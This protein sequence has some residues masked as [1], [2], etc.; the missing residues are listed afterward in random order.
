MRVFQPTWVLAAGGAAAGLLA[1]TQP[2]ALLLSIIAAAILAAAALFTPLA[3]AGIMLVLAPLRTLVITEAVYNL[4]LDP[5]QLLFIVTLALWAFYRIRHR[6]PLFAA[7]PSP[8]Y[9]PVLGFATLT[10]LTLFNTVSPAAWLTEW[11]KWLV[12]LLLIVFVLDQGRH[13]RWQWLLL[14]LVAAAAANAVVGLYIFFGGSGADHL[15]INNRFFRAFGTFGQ[16]NPFGGFMGLTLPLALMAAYGYSLRLFRNW[17]NRPLKPQA[18]IPPVF[19]LM[20]ALLLASGVLISWSRGA[21]LA[22]AVAVAVM[23]FALPYRLRYSLL[24]LA[25]AG[26]LAAAAW[27]GGLLPASIIERVTG[28]AEELLAFEDVRGVEITPANYAVIERL[29]HWQAALNMAR[30]HPWLGVGLGAYGAA[31]DQYRL[32]NWHEPL[33]HAHNYY[34]NI[35]AEAGIIGLIGYSLLWAMVFLFTWR[36]R[37]HPDPLARALG[38]GLLGAWVYLAVHSLLDNLYVNNLFLHLGVMFGILAVL[39][40][41][42]S[43]KVQLRWQ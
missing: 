43:R 17:R 27:F 26:S 36:L 3:A 15:L 8:V 25:L 12:I 34:L 38:I 11:L 40:N 13:E 1:A 7:L 31:Y 23:A 18:F 2:V 21:W 37:R 19:Y 41:Q 28:S 30:H 5:G 22:M 24:L 6:Q 9:L 42:V 32:L 16:P 29:A 10:A 35:L 4:P 39:Y 33:G 20:M 14:A